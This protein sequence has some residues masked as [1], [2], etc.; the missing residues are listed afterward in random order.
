MISGFGTHCTDCPDW[1]LTLCSGV[2][3]RA[4]LRRVE[5]RSHMDEMQSHAER[6]AWRILIGFFIVFLVV[7]SSGVWLVQWYIFRSMVDLETDLKVARGT[8]SVILPNTQEP[9]AVTDRRSDLQIGVIIQTDEKSQAILTFVDP[10]TKQ[11]V[12]SLVIFP[13]SSIVLTQARSP[14]FGLNST[15][16][17]IEITN[18]MGRSEVSILESAQRTT[19]FNVTA[20]QVVISMPRSGLYTIE[21]TD[22]R[23]WVTVH[24]GEASITDRDTGELTALSA[25]NRVL[26]DS[27][28]KQLLPV[29]DE[30]PLVANSNFSEDYQR[31][32]QFYSIG[33]VAGTIKS[34]TFDG[35]SAVVIDRSQNN[36]PGQVLDHGEI[37]LVQSVD[38][39]VNDHDSIELRLTLYVEEQS[40]ALCGIAGSECPLMIRIT[41]I[42]TSGTERVYIHG[43]YAQPD[44]SQGYP[45]LC[46]TCRTEHERINMGSWYTFSKNLLVLLP[47]EQRPVHIKELRFY[48]S[49]HAFK[50]Y[51]SEMSL[52]GAQSPAVLDLQ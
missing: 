23:T 9:I 40:L 48:A 10:S 5:K 27:S 38:T 39:N 49:G 16:Y 28:A 11:P 2:Q 29:P 3:S 42:D 31:G 33:D 41:Y 43:F 18:S 36:W 46:D 19:H 20:P 34:V 47:A 12:A 24:S 7:C 1:K 50:V 17:Q 6:R 35:R 51:V 26:V 45:V 21:T 37:G 44:N 22:Q 30:K 14:R 15:S 52:L 8:V 13:D 4:V 25:N 32:W